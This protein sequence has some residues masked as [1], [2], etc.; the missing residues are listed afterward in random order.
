MRS[1]KLACGTTYTLKELEDA[2][3]SYVPCGTVKGIDKPL[4]KYTHLWG[5]ELQ[6]RRST[7]GDEWNTYVTE[8]MSGVQLMTGKPS[9]RSRDGT[10]EYL[11]DIDIE[12]RLL[13][14]YPEH[15]QRIID[16][17]RAACI[18][19]PCIIRTKSGG[20]RLSAFAPGYQDKI[21]FTEKNVEDIENDKKPM[22]LEFFSLKGLSRIDNQYSLIEG[23]LSTIPS[24]PKSAYP[25]MHAIISEIGTE[26][27]RKTRTHHVVASEQISGIDIEWSEDGDSYK[28]QSFPSEYCQVTSHSSNRDTV[29]FYK[30]P[31]GS[32]IGSC[33]NCDE[34]WY[35]VP[36][37]KQ[38]SHPKLKLVEKSTPEP[39][40][41]PEQNEARRE[42]GITA[43]INTKLGK[44]HKTHIT[45]VTDV[46]GSGKSH[47]VLAKA[48]AL[49]KRLIGLLP[50][51]D[52][53]E[54][55]VKLA[56]DLG[57]TRPFFLKGRG[58][59]WHESKIAEI[60][61]ENRD[62]TLFSKNL[63]IMYDEL[64][65][66]TDKRLAAG[67]YCFRMCPFLENC[68]YWKQY[69]L[70]KKA[71]AVF[72]CTPNLLFNP[73]MLGYLRR[74]IKAETPSETDDVLAAALGT[75]ADIADD[76]DM[77]VIDDYTVASLFNE[78]QI[79][80]SELKQLIKNWKGYALGNF[81]KEIAQAFLM[82][83]RAEIYQHIQTTIE[84]L[85]TK[86]RKSLRKQMTKHPRWGQITELER[87]LGSK[88]TEKV[89]SEWEIIFDDGGRAKV[90]I[91]DD[92]FLELIRKN[93]PAVR[94]RDNWTVEDR[95]M[96]R[97]TPF[98]A[99]KAGVP[100]SELS[101][102]WQR[103]WTLLHQLQHFL[104]GV[105]IPKN[106]PVT[107]E[108]ETLHF[109]TPP[110][111]NSLIPKIF[112]LSATTDPKDTRQSFQGQRG[113]KWTEIIG[114]P[115]Q[116]A[117]GVKVYQF[118]Q[119]RITSASTFKYK[120]DA[121]GKRLLQTAPTGLTAITEKRFEKLNNL[122]QNTEGV[123][124]FI[125]YKDIA[126]TPAFRDKLNVFDV[127]THFD[128]V[129]GLNIENLKLLVIYGYPK[130]SHK[131]VMDTARI[132][133]AYSDTPL[134]EGDYETLTEL[135]TYTEAGIEITERR[136]KDPR[137][138]AI[139]LQLATDKL[140]QA[141]G[142]ARLSRWT[143]T[144]TVLYT[145]APLPSITSRTI[146]FKDREFHATDTLANMQ[147]T[148]VKI[149]KAIADGDVKAVSETQGV[150]ERTAQRKTKTARETE[151]EKR[152]ARI[153]E[154]LLAGKS[155]RVIMAQMQ[156]EGYK[157][158]SKSTISRLSQNGQAQLRLLIG[159]GENGTPPQNVDIP[160]IH[161][162]SAA[163]NSEKTYP[164]PISKD[165]DVPCILEKN[166]VRKT[167][168]SVILSLSE[169]SKLTYAEAIEQ[170]KICEAES[171]YNGAAV[172]RKMFREKGW[173]YENLDT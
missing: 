160:C 171:N 151:K 135:N 113:I 47:T 115:I 98:G 99:L 157:H 34:T 68:P 45:L 128:R 130:V 172:L 120:K 50:H 58:Q 9:N 3:L 59:N 82:D 65:K 105:Q 14:M 19:E 83:T 43:A 136:Y 66:H 60:P 61:V 156:T 22:L 167:E 36:P 96:V 57:F 2:Q 32:I 134:P 127:V 89:L 173:D 158:V 112:L 78:Q 72:T 90:A 52:L 154:L 76:F 106:A 67:E 168:K 144:E 148:A 146:L 162:E 63:C 69:E 26:N 56:H 23:S 42:K 80:L 55:A 46:T 18:G 104:R 166:A 38:K 4:V 114:I 102:V 116:W 126:D 94:C 139:R 110:R 118:S 71:D 12:A 79:T 155:V 44:T 142:R 28:S 91:N 170:M 100:L 24:V 27:S 35:E 122:A 93:I 49:G 109:T 169:Y 129:E 88:E 70:L 11:T 87:P 37:K 6:V 123:S 21:S 15:A 17:Y 108:K 149:E 25:E 143:D 163:E 165:V 92:A 152:N 39:T 75:A 29:V 31:D 85:D 86:T 141:V 147:E 20:L 117:P 164:M 74:L 41:T 40:E 131:V 159:N 54:Q 137:L 62:E 13:E 73:A 81:A 10:D 95:V 111:A 30:N 145:N 53:A 140:I 161:D 5:E 51:K 97:Y 48:K 64:E 16:I 101:P 84:G 77:A 121:D 125:S 138:E 119:H 150:S 153:A 1:V 7:Y 8:N 124:V 133:F 103:R 132:Q 33:I 107:I